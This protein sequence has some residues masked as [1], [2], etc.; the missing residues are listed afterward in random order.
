MAFIKLNI[1]YEARK[2][3]HMTFFDDEDN[4]NRFI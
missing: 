1:Y 4:N 2:S 3:R